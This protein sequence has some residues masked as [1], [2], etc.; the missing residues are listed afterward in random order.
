M[1]ASISLAAN[2][3]Q[4]TPATSHSVTFRRQHDWRL[5]LAIIVRRHRIMAEQ[6]ARIARRLADR[7]YFN[8]I[9]LS[10]VVFL[11]PTAAEQVSTP[12]QA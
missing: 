10:T 12:H 2:G 6:P 5:A 8:R 9:I 11:R 7:P 4:Y 1:A 3:L